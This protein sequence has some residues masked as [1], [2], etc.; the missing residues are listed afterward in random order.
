MQLGD[1]L[2]VVGEAEAIQGVEKI[3]GNAVKQLNEPNLIPVFIGL[4]LGLTLG[5]IPLA[6]P[7]IRLPVKLGL[8][9][10]PIILGILIG[11]FGPRIHIVTYTTLSANLMLRIGWASL[12]GLPGAR[13]GRPFRRNDHAP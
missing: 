8:A 3:L 11:T 13:S 9:G 1:S 7:G 6:V 2:T 4:I 12:S 5:S 10:G